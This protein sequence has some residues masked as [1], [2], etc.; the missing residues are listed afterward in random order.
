MAENE[1]EQGR[2]PETQGRKTASSPAGIATGPDPGFRQRSMGIIANRDL[3]LAFQAVGVRSFPVTSR[4]EA[5]AAL[6]RAQEENF[7]IL[8]VSSDWISHLFEDIEKIDGFPLVVEIPDIKG[9]TSRSED[10]ISKIIERAVGVDINKQKG[11]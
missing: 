10:F 2:T 6:R 3:T 11:E 7:A 4:E 5:R 9:S 1:E 8:F